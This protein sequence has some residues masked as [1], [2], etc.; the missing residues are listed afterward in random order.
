MPLFM[1]LGL[2]FGATFD[3][4]P[5]KIAILPLTFLMVYPMMVNLNIKQVFSGGDSKLQLTTQALNFLVIP[6]LGL[7]I[8][9]LFFADSPMVI[10]GLLLTSLLPTSGMTISWTGFARG[11]MPAA[12]KMTAIGLIL[13][14]VLTP[15][16]LRLLLGAHVEIPMFEVFS[17]II[18]VVFLPMLLGFVTQQLL[19]RRYGQ[20]RYQKDI[21]NIFPPLSTA[22]VLSVVF[23]AMALKSKGILADPMVLLRYAVPLAVMYVAN[24]AISTVV[25]KYFFSRADGIALVYG[26]VMR[27]LSIA[28]AIAMTVFGEQGS[29]IALI[30]AIAYIIQVQAGA[31]YVRYTDVIFGAAP[32]DVARDVMHRGVFFIGTDRTIKEAV[33]ML[34]DEHIHSLIVQ[35]QD[36][37]SIGILN[38]RN[39]FDHIVNVSTSENDTV[40]SVVLKPLLIFDEMAPLHQIV[41][42]MKENNVYKVLIHNAKQQPVGVITETIYLRKLLK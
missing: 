19:V 35:N 1:L 31:W 13:G 42:Q 17:Q 30:I 41:T 25:G 3:A 9:T 39:L 16:Y 5:L 14:S 15:L 10:L 33:Q 38:T 20:A 4:S 12:V 29:E 40:A 2:L 22:G 28:L 18:I 37:K 8:G 32:P 34:E 24:F 26:S 6:F 27:N 11:N 36:G 21:K 23:V 7:A